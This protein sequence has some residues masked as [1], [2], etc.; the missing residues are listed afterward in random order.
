MINSTF[1]AGLA[2]TRSMYN[3][4]DLFKRY[5]GETSLGCGYGNT[6]ILPRSSLHRAICV[7]Q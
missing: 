6:N 1:A 2:E 4:T 5:S 7:S 3:K